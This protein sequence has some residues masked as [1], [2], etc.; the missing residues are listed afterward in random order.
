MPDQYPLVS[1]ITVNY[2]QIGVTCELF[3]SLR[4]IDYP[5]LE[6]ILVDNGSKVDETPIIATKYPEVKIIISE[7]NLGFA[8]GNNL[9]VEEAKGEYLFFINNDTEIPNGTIPKL[10]EAF[11]KIPNLGMISP[12][13]LYWPEEKGVNEIIQYVGA[14]PVSNITA[15][16]K[17]LGEMEPDNNQYTELK[18]TPY[19]HGAAMMIPKKVINEVGMMFEDFFLYYEELDWCEQIR[20][21]GYKIYVEP[22]VHVYHKESISV[23]K[24]STLK[25]Y[26]LNRNRIYFMKRNRSG[27]HVFLFSLFLIFVTVPKN[28][29]MF[30]LRGDWEHAKVFLKA[31]WWNVG[32]PKTT[33]KSK[34]VTA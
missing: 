15:R 1:L 27:F 6:I 3:D 9:A 4:A 2:N 31:V 29:L 30:I 34:L 23:G 28:V 11:D 10:L 18:E 13:L 32:S 12:K 19:A 26:Y 5:N 25:T 17:I 21:A 22:N 20:R 16:N 7:E 24:M 8:G 14:T 33:K